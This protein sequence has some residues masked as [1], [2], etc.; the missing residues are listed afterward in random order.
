[1]EAPVERPQRSRGVPGARPEGAAAP[2]WKRPRE[3]PGW[4]RRIAG[5]SP[6]GSARQATDAC[7]E[8]LP[9]AG[10]SLIRANSIYCA[11][12]YGEEDIMKA[13]PKNRSK[14]RRRRAALKRKHTKARL[15]V[16]S[17]H[18]KF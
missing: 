10:A 4:Q 15:R 17:G 3:T 9:G 2:L 16:S 6:L 1:M 18:Q 14:S 12:F 5:R 11:L 7:H 13:S 8:L